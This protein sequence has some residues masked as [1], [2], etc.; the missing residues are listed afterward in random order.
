MR[1]FTTMRSRVQCP[2][3]MARQLWLMTWVCLSGFAECI[4]RV[5]APSGTHPTADRCVR[6][7]EWKREEVVDVSQISIITMRVLFLKLCMESTLILCLGVCIIEIVG[8][9]FCAEKNCLASVFCAGHTRGML[10]RNKDKW[11]SYIA[12]STK[13]M[14][15]TRI[16][17]GHIKSIKGRIVL[18]M[19]P[20]V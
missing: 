5:A 7:F 6:S 12:D 19:N 14:T 9:K 20:R 2:F 16:E 8:F 4:T 18:K 3:S 11:D 13:K 1:N 15:D 10:W 17:S